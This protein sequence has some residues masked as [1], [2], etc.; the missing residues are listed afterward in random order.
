LTQAWFA[1]QLSEVEFQAQSG[2]LQA[3]AGCPGSVLLA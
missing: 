3:Q 1:A 2:P